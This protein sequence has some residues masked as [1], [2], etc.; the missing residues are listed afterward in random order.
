MRVTKS[1][2]YTEETVTKIE[3]ANTVSAGIRWGAIS[4]E[5]VPLYEEQVARIEAHY[6]MDAWYALDP[7]ERAMVIA[8][9][10]IGNAM[11]N[12]QME[13]E[14]KAAKGKGRK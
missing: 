6:T 4:G 5:F 13:A 3:P 12:L 2:G 1:I 7:L 8:V 11:Q 10:R 14:I 9:R